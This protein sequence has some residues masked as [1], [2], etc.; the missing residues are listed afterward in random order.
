MKKEEFIKPFERIREILRKEPLT[1]D[2]D[3]FLT[4]KFWRDLD[5]GIDDLTMKEFKSLF[6]AGYFGLPASITRLRAL[7]QN[8]DPELRG[9]VTGKRTA[10]SEIFK[11]FVKSFP[12]RQEIKDPDLIVIIDNLEADRALDIMATAIKADE[13]AINGKSVKD[14]RIGKKENIKTQGEKYYS[15]G[16]YLAIHKKNMIL[17]FNQAQRLKEIS[18]KLNQENGLDNKIRNGSGVREGYRVEVFR[19][20]ILEKAFN[21]LQKENETGP[22]RVV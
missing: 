15:V 17:P 22:E 6:L 10:R 3:L 9:T 13:N 2:D 14:M 4:W 20:S 11:S 8:Q 16:E 19:F 7:C 5:P 12:S 21:E 1:R 18:R